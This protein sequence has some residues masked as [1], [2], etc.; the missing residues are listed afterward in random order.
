MSDETNAPPRAAADD[1]PPPAGSAADANRAESADPRPAPDFHALEGGALERFLQRQKA[2]SALPAEPDLALQ[3]AQLLERARALVPSA[4]GAILLDDPLRKG[5]DPA[6]NDLHVV[7]AFGPGAR[8]LLGLRVPASRGIAGRVYRTGRPQLAVDGA[9]GARFPDQAGPAGRAARSVI[10]APVGIGGTVF[11]VIELADRLDGEPF[12]A[13]DL[14]LLEIFAGYTSST[15][16]NALDAKR[17]LELAK[18]DDLTGLFNDRWLHLRLIEMIGEAD[19]RGEPCALVFLDLDHFKA[20]NDTYGHLAGSEVLRQ[21]G[22]VL[23]RAVDHPGAVLAR[24]G[25]DEFV[26]GLGAMDADAGA[27]V[28]ERVRAAVEGATFLDRPF[29]PGLPALHLRGA[30]TASVGV[31]VY[32]PDDAGGPTHRK[33][34]DLLRRADAAMYAAKGRGK[35]RVVVS[36]D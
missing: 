32:R 15:L 8:E 36:E 5:D 16:Q 29:G 12:E 13:R 9:D 21:V 19:R 14:A 4:S 6:R 23:R 34:G 2:T 11:G 28:A 7:A 30:V 25:G 35:N 1:E 31:A 17:L 3:L 18:R 22:F 24:Y 33:E 27:A 20:V 26:V 10:A